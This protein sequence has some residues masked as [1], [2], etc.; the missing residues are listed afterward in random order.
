MPPRDDETCREFID[1]M[2]G[3]L[4]SPERRLL[5]NDTAVYRYWLMVWDGAQTIKGQKEEAKKMPEP[6]RN[7]NSLLRLLDLEHQRV[8]KRHIAESPRGGIPVGGGDWMDTF[9][10]L[11]ALEGTISSLM[12][13]ESVKVAI[14]RGQQRSTRAV[15]KWNSQREWQ[16]HRWKEMAWDYL[17]KL[18]WRLQRQ[19]RM[20]RNS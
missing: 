12:A 17:E 7:H 1:R 9:F 16:V 14:E 5:R 19:V 4:G 13:F 20:R 8:Y 3:A 15:K 6:I 2:L 18:V 11:E 10:R